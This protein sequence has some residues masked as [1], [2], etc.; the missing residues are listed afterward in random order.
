MALIRFINNPGKMVLFNTIL[1]PNITQIGR[2]CV[3]QHP[4]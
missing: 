4:K 3:P 2:W 1:T